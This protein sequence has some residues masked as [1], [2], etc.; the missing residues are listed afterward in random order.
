MGRVTVG[1]CDSAGGRLAVVGV[2]EVWPPVGASWTP[3]AFEEP[4]Q[5]PS[6]AAT[7]SAQA[8]MVGVRLDIGSVAA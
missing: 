4:P 1:L 5:A 8:S 2:A 7:S 3:G 6:P